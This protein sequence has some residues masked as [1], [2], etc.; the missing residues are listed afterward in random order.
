MKQRT[1]I[2]NVLHCHKVADDANYFTV[3]GRDLAFARKFIFY[4]KGPIL[5]SFRLICAGLP[6]AKAM[7]FFC[8]FARIRFL[9]KPDTKTGHA[10]AASFFILYLQH[11]V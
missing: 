1:P 3:T 5:V 2:I 8:E 10:V 4:R 11:E 9:N 6:A 7:Q